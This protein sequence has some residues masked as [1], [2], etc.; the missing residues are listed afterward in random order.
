[1]VV[2]ARAAIGSSTPLVVVVE[3]HATGTGECFKA[4]PS[5]LATLE[6]GL[7]GDAQVCSCWNVRLAANV[8]EGPSTPIYRFCIIA[9]LATWF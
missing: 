1:M 5:E 3:L 6:L 4:K 7:N 9:S 8:A 2:V